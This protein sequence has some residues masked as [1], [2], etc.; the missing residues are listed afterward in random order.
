MDYEPTGPAYPT[1]DSYFVECMDRDGGSLTRKTK[2]KHADTQM[3]IADEL[4]RT[5][6]DEY[7]EDVLD[8]MEVMEVGFL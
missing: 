8:H 3:Q 6:S 7:L 4:S 2:E 5:V 1:C